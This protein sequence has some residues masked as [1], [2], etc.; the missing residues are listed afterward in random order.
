MPALSREEA[1]G[2]IG[3]GATTR[4]DDPASRPRFSVGDRVVAGNPNP[5][6]H[7]RLPRYARCKTGTITKVHGVF[8]L[9]DSN[10][11]RAGRNEQGCYSVRFDAEELWGPQGRAGDCLFID[12]W[13][14]YLEP[15]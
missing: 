11:L 6:T 7:T 12:M 8:A 4:V 3:T 14:A 2:L 10:A 13:D 1:L 9:P 5:F 15:A